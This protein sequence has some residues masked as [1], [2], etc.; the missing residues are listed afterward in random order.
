MTKLYDILKSHGV[1][2]YAVAKAGGWSWQQV[3]AW[4]KGSR[5]MQLKTFIE[6]QQV[7]TDNFGIEIEITDLKKTESNE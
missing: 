1:T 5:T 3:A 6:L 4:V 7:M 2:M